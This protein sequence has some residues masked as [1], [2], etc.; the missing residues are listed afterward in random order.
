M[1]MSIRSGFDPPADDRTR[2]GIGVVGASSWGSNVV[3]TFAAASGASLR[4]VCDLRPELLARVSA[5]HPGV[6][7]TQSFD[8]LLAD[9]GVAAVAVAVDGANHHRLARRALE[10]GRH[11]LVEKPLALTVADSEELCAM[12]ER[13]Q[14]ILMVGHLSLYHPGVL[15]AK[16]E[17]DAGELGDV[18]Y[19]HS[20]RVKRGVT[21]ATENAWWSLAPHDVAVALYL[22]GAQPSTVSATGGAYLRTRRGSEDVVFATLAFADGR[23]AHIHVSRVD[24]DQRRTLTV[25]GEQ[26]T[27]TVDQMLP[28]GA[29]DGGLAPVQPLTAEC[30]H[31]IH[32]VRTGQR[33][34]SDGAQGLAVVR[35][36]D[37]GERSMR[38]GGAPV[39]VS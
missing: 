15:R 36:L 33:P 6:R 24:T 13:A 9:S 1:P 25:V 38:K 21:R 11:V 2:L 19:I 14:R 30:E 28:P 26:R 10:S 4:G 16:R 20:E 22:F 29:V 34:R 18:R 3:R 39:A 27:L 5:A 17:M 7:V 32:C 23:M 37:A 12:A 31:F 8:D 35:V